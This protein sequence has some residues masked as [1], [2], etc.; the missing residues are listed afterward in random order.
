MAAAM[1]P[2]GLKH[3]RGDP[4]S[5]ARD[6]PR[7]RVAAFSASLDG[8]LLLPGEDGWDDAVRI[9]NGMIKRRPGLVVRPAGTPDV[10]R[11]VTFAR[12]H[13][14]ELSIKVGG[15]NIAGLCL[16]DS[17]ITMAMSGLRCVVV[18][19][20]ARRATIDAGCNLGDVDRATQVHG[21]ATA[22]GFVSL[23][24]VA[25]LTVGGGF[26]YLSRRFGW[27]VDDLL[28]GEIVTADGIVRRASRDEDP[29]LFWAVRGGGGNFGVI[30]QFVFRLHAVGPT[31]TAGLIAWP[32]SEADGVLELFRRATGTAP[33]E[34]T[35]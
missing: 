10:A 13:D 29:D 3:D 26:G 9:W 19:A 21:L 6:L 30:T 17:G 11:T 32:A 23:T 14:L 16:S 2:H 33:P 28:E 27:T 31:V 15:H 5:A 34:L 4:I 18:N 35:P 7:D 24:G 8:S 20:K 25:G 22:L 1:E 12:D